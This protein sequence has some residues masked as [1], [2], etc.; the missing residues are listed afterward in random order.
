MKNLT[1]QMIKD[2][3]QENAVSFK[4]NASKAIY[5][6]LGDRLEEKYAELSKEFL[7]PKNETNN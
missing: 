5:D 6:K 1:R 7:R 3:I 2:I 4:E